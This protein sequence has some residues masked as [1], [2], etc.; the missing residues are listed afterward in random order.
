MWPRI[1]EA[2]PATSDLHRSAQHERIER[3]REDELRVESALGLP[4]NKD[5]Q[6]IDLSGKN[7]S[8]RIEMGEH[9]LQQD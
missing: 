8:E 3:H 7:N 4:L 6:I 9:G 1:H 2:H 5:R